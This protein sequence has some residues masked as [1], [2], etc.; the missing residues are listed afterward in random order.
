MM[1]NNADQKKLMLECRHAEKRETSVS[2]WNTGEVCGEDHHG[3]LNTVLRLSRYTE[4]TCH[5]LRWT[6][7]LL[8]P[9]GVVCACVMLHGSQPKSC[10]NLLSSQ[11]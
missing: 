10:V 8:L 11:C 6:K 7:P 3:E 4:M 1:A 2:A 9:F 5:H